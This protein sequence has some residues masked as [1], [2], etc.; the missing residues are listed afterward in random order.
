MTR[1]TASATGAV[2]G[3]PSSGSSIRRCSSRPARPRGIARWLFSYPSYL[4][5]W[6]LLY[7]AIAVLVWLYLTPATATLETLAPGW[8]ALVLARN[9]VLTLLFFGAFHLRLYIR[10]S[11][12]QMFK[13]N[14]KWLDTDHP[15][16]LRRR[17][18]FD[19][20]FGP[21]QRRAIWTAYEVVTLWLYAKV[22]FP[23]HRLANHPIWFV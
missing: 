15:S 6:N 5:P 11:Q 13:F 2:I 19:N 9:L 8:I 3:S 21:R 23:C 12:G 14:P 4:L 1:A 16:F 18:I 20:M 10:K 17:Q 22:T 7:G